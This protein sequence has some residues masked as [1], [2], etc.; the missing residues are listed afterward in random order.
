MTRTLSSMVEMRLA[1]T[2]R[3]WFFLNLLFLTGYFQS[4][5]PYVYNIPLLPILLLLL[6]YESA[7]AFPPYRKSSMDR[8]PKSGVILAP[9]SAVPILS[10]L[11]LKHLSPSGAVL[12]V[13]GIA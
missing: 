5:M 1:E 10:T 6:L 2:V 4:A 13:T 9:T 8:G 7:F 11:S 3:D 12:F